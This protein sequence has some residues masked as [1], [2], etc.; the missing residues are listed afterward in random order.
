MSQSIRSR[1]AIFVFRSAQKNTNLVEDIEFL[2]IVKFRWNLFSGF[3][4]KVENVSANQRPGGHLCFS[5]RPEN[6]ILVEGI[7][8]YFLSSFVEICS[9]VSEKK[10]KM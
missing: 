4:G 7:E 10:S 3:R 2:L 1:A 5:D 9:A 8:I 6:I